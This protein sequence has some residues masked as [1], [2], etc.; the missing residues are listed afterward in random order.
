MLRKLVIANLAIFTVAGCEPSTL[1]DEDDL[2]P[3]AIDT[4][5]GQ[6]VV[7]SDGSL[8]TTLNV[9]L[10]GTDVTSGNGYAYVLGTDQ[11]GLQF[12]AIAGIANTTVLGTPLE[13]GTATFSGNYRVGQIDNIRLDDTNNPLFSSTTDSGQITLTANFDTLTLTGSD[14]DLN[15]DGS[16]SGGDLAGT[17]TYA[18]VDGILAGEIGTNATVGSFSGHDVNTVFAGGF[19]AQVQ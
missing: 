15:I 14:N 16:I 10:S 3:A 1:F 7:G 19:T 9:E 4:D 18:G 13:S 6:V 17:V 5:S 11:T 8:A 2:P 12:E